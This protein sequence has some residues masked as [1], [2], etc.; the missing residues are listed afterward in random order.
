[1]SI[2]R[3]PFRLLT[4]ELG[5]SALSRA[6]R[7]GEVPAGWMA[8]TPEHAAAW[9]ERARRVMADHPDW[10][11]AI[12]PALGSGVAL[13]RPV[14]HQGVVIT[15]GQQPGLFGGPL[16]TLSK[17][18]SALA[19][20]EA[21][22]R[23][24]GIPTR[25]V[26]WAATDDADFVEAASIALVGAAGLERLT[27]T[28]GA[29]EEL[30]PLALRPLGPE[31]DLLRQR[32]AAACGSVADARAL[33][34]AAEFRPGRTIGDA[35][36]AFLRAVLEPLG[37]P[38]LDASHPAVAQATRPFLDRALAEASRVHE[39]LLERTAAISTAGYDAPVAV[40][41]ALS[42]VFAWEGGGDDAQKRRVPIT[43]AAMAAARGDRLSP[44]VLLRPV[45]ESWLLP[46][47]T[48]VAGPGELAYFA[49]VGAVAA[50]LGE[51][52]PL[53][54]PRWSGVIVPADVDGELRS[55]EWDLDVLRD[56]HAVENAIA[57]A[58]VPA[59][60]VAMFARLRATVQQELSALDAVLP[61]P[62]IAGAR[63]DLGRRLDRIERRVRGTV[64]HREQVVLQRLARARATIF[65]HGVPQERYL[66]FVPFLARYGAPLLDAQRAAARDHASRWW[67][68]TP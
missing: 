44:N 62:A 65:P 39:A 13:L 18:L 50:A 34:A 61:S 58:A 47:V 37:I 30:R 38:V 53:A 22:E 3:V 43:E 64:K 6:I 12:A 33:E 60:V 7:A 31:V 16:Y 10:L 5:G 48:Y 20:S 9:S 11:G 21:H 63:G 32:L 29:E 66:S 8:N 4:T 40:D 67:P 35:Y 51:P 41:R 42:L 15:T 28:S 49:Q 52:V 36:V 25:P 45:M 68:P 17:A 56:P 26:F 54:L 23:A 24:T 19:M 2:D 46:T 27:L 1:V 57:A 59:E 55:R 14:E